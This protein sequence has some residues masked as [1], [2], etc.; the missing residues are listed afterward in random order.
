MARIRRE[1]LARHT[2]LLRDRR[3]MSL[4]QHRRQPRAARHREHDPRAVRARLFRH[5]RPAGLSRPPR[6]RRRRLPDLHKRRKLVLT[7]IV[8]LRRPI[9]HG[10]RLPR[11]RR[12]R[13]H[14]RGNQPRLDRGP[15]RASLLHRSERR[16]RLRDATR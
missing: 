10:L 6:Q 5:P 2:T 7:G 14:V 9:R 13:A 1:T 12:R 15:A 4:H 8:L 16:P 11:R 3:T